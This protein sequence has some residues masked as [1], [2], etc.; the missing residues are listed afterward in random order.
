V[1]RGKLIKDYGAIFG[2]YGIQSTIITFDNKY[3]FANSTGGQLKQISLESQEI[4]GDYGKIN[5]DVIRC[6]ETSRDSKW[7][8]ISDDDF[9]VKRISVENR[10]FDKDFGK[11]C[12]KE[13]NKDFDEVCKSFINTDFGAIRG[14]MIMKIKITVDD[15]KLLVADFWNQFKL[16]SSRDGALIKDFGNVPDRYITGIMITRDQKFFFTSSRYGVLKQWNYEENTL[17][18]NHGRITDNI[19]SLC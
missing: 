12:N 17:V 1:G 6:L 11:V 4:V 3:L 16:I 18:T 5:N 7:V 14:G 2:V 15:E 13:F 8:F 19:N 9:H 10:E